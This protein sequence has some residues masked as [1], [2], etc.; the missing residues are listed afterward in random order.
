MT[1]TITKAVMSLPPKFWL[2]GTAASI[3]FLALFG[4]NHVTNAVEAPAA[5]STMTEEAMEE[6]QIWSK[7]ALEHIFR[8]L[9][10][11]Q[12]ENNSLV[13]HNESVWKLLKDTYRDV[14]HE[15]IHSL[16]PPSSKSDSL[17]GYQVPVEIKKTKLE[18][19]QEETL[20]VFTKAAISK[21]TLIW[22]STNTAQFT[23]GADFRTYLKALPEYLACD[24]IDWAFPRFTAD[25]E[26]L[27]CVDLDHGSLTN[28]CVLEE[29][30]NME[31]KEEL[32]ENSGCEMEFYATRNIAA[33][34]ELKLDHD[35]T[36]AEL[37][38]VPLGLKAPLRT[39]LDDYEGDDDDD[40]D[41]DEDEDEDD[42]EF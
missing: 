9:E 22:K 13:V 23:S 26:P 19:G 7:G 11:P 16:P 39:H 21:G 41:D 2:I 14:V 40:D 30:C 6:T 31:V 8:W 5:P 17:K 10:C 28:A 33:G 24:I 37:A 25:Q 38:F 35:F 12:E 15:D 20:G 29:E 36:E 4:Q 32:L 42:Q 34:E 1:I 18:D 3:F 27:V